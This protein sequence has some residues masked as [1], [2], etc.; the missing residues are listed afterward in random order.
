MLYFAVIVLWADVDKDRP[1]NLIG[2]EKMA[3]TDLS[4]FLLFDASQGFV[5]EKSK[6][7]V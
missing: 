4:N 7:P 2:E 3:R 1:A 5:P 6:K